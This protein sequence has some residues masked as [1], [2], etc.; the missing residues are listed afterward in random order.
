LN[1]IDALVA[2]RPAKGEERHEASSPRYS[3]RQM[4]SD[5][6]FGR[7]AQ[8]GYG[9]LPEQVVGDDLHARGIPLEGLYLKVCRFQ[10]R[11]ATTGHYAASLV[12]E[13]GGIL[14]VALVLVITMALVPR[15][16]VT[17]G[18]G[19]FAHGHMVVGHGGHR[20]IRHGQASPTEEEAN[21]HSC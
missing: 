16:L 5:R 19:L 10:G 3:R 6:G 20:G 4:A 15:R 13:R 7:A 2:A 11:H 8:G 9:A 21:Q 18:R 12:G 17:V 1:W 14:V